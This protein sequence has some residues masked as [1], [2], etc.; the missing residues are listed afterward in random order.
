MR[1]LSAFVIALGLCACSLTAPLSGPR[2]N[3]VPADATV[4]AENP[5]AA[6]PASAAGDAECVRSC[7]A[8]AE[9]EYNSCRARTPGNESNCALLRER[10]YTDCASQCA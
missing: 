3:E 10:I 8:R 6:G 7:R 1:V 9:G 5:D 2:E 4:V